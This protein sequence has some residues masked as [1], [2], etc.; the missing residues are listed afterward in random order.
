MLRVDLIQQFD[1][2]LLDGCHVRKVRVW[3]GLIVLAGCVVRG[4]LGVTNVDAA[5]LAL[6]YVESWLVSFD[7]TDGRLLDLA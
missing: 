2:L 4:C 3:K 5:P 6:E 7:L 1:Q